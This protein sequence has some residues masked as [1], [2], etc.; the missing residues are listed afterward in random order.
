MF[1][2]TTVIINNSLNNMGSIKAPIFGCLGL[3]PVSTELP[4]H[5][6]RA[7]HLGTAAVNVLPVSLDAGCRWPQKAA[8]K[9][10]LK[11]GHTYINPKL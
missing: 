3:Y 8:E 4:V 9:T 7:K 1:F 2:Y 11:R 6:Y 10:A 5:G